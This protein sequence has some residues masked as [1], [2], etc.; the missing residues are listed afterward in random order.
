MCLQLPGSS[1]Q[2]PAKRTYPG[3]PSFMRR[4]GPD[5]RGYA[6]RW[7]ARSQAKAGDEP[8][9][10]E[11]RAADRNEPDDEVSQHDEEMTERGAHQRGEGRIA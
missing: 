10:D 5:G 3:L 4:F 2:V 1:L 7:E 9:P 11:A 8:T 6:E